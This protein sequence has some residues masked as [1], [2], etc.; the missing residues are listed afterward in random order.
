MKKIIVIIAAIIMALPVFAQVGR[1]KNIKTVYPGYTLKFDTATAELT[2]MHFD[3]ETGTIDETVIS[4]KQSHSH[5]QVGRYEF[6]RSARVATYQI[7]D[8]STGEYTTV[9]WSP[10]GYDYESVDTQIDTLVSRTVD[11]IKLLL[12][13]LEEGIDKLG[14]SLQDTVVVI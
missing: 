7:F 14:S 8:T 9:K 2:V 13:G 6:R 1:F 12:K 3:D 4:K 5:K 10:D 11:G